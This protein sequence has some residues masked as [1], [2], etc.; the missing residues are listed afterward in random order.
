MARE[1]KEIVL[2]EEA[3][4]EE[5]KQPVS[6]E[7]KEEEVNIPRVIRVSEETDN[8]VNCL[9]NEKVVVR[10]IAKAR[11]SINDRRH[12]LFGNMAENA[13]VQ[14]TTPLLR[15][16]N[17]ADVL[18]K[19]EKKFLE[20]ILGLESNALS[21]YARGDNNFWNDANPQG[22]GRITLKKGD[23]I[24]DLSVPMDYIK[25]KVLLA[26]KDYIAPSLEALRDRPKATYRF[27]VIEEQDADKDATSRVDLKAKA[28]MEFGRISNDKDK[29]RVVIETL[30]GRPTAGNSKLDY[31]KGKVGELLEDSPKLF[32]KVV[33]DS[34]LDNKVLIR[35]AIDIGVV[36]NRGNYYYV[37]DGNLPLCGNGQ[38]P[39]INVAAQFL[40]HPKNQELKF[41][42]E[43][44]VK[45]AYE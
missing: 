15:S 31:L 12:V 9:R 35:K 16:G 37:K 13:K 20:H 44:K 33:T 43:A 39:T 38:E 5:V 29:L 17:F 2:D 8:L 14:Y 11:G 21:V 22:V 45:Q 41:S 7:R 27:V 34:L 24:F 25:Y 42:I 19:E 32:L 3:L 10:F 18:T 4:K 26:N 36:V 23:N 28:Y 40:S 6:I 1:K 30:D